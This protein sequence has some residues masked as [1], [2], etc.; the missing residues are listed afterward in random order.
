MDWGLT[1]RLVLGFAAI[2]I[3][4]AQFTVRYAVAKSLGGTLARRKE[5][6]GAI[7]GFLL[8]VGIGVGNL[9]HLN[10]P[11]SPSTVMISLGV[12]ASA[13]ALWAVWVMLAPVDRDRL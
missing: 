10:T 7:A 4:G 3:A 2:L 8:L 1:L 12:L 11:A 13:W 9:T 6:S 5:L